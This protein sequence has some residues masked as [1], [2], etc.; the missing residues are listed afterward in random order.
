MKLIH[1]ILG[2][3][4]LNKTTVGAVMADFQVKIKQLEAVAKQQ[5]LDADKA[6][7]RSQELL[8]KRECCLSEIDLAHRTK[9]ALLDIVTPKSD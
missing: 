1:I 8:R 3:L 5:R 4:G 9:Q 2:F 7:Q 6:Y